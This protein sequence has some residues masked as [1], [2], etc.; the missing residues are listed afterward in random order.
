MLK[1]GFV[2]VYDNNKRMYRVE[3]IKALNR[4]EL[5]AEYLLGRPNVYATEDGTG[6]AITGRDGVQFYIKKGETLG[7]DEIPPMLA[8]IERAGDRLKRIHD[9][10]EKDGWTG[11][12]L[13]FRT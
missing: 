4:S 11:K 3:T 12:R 5:P 9:H 8:I 2:S 10:M 6:L 13:V 1:V 7:P